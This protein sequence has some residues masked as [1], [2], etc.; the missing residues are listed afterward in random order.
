LVDDKHQKGLWQ[1]KPFCILQNAI[2][3]WGWAFVFHGI[4]VATL[5]SMAYHWGTLIEVKKERNQGCKPP[6]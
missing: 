5:G 4:I 1:H 3:F 2:F 6:P